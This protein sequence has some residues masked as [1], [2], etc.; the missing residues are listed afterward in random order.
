[1][2]RQIEQGELQLIGI[3][4]D[5]TSL[6]VDIDFHFDGWPDRLSKQTTHPAQQL[7]QIDTAHLHA[8]RA[9]EGEQLSRQLRTAARRIERV[10]SEALQLFVFLRAGLDQV[11]I[12]DDR[13]EQ[14]VEIVRNAAG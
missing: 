11:E 7:P 13:G 1:V 8:L 5:R 3:T 6:R 2:H 4:D 10:D 12:A 9:R 14:I